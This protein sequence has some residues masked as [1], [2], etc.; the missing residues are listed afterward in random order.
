MLQLAVA[1]LFL[2]A[3]SGCLWAAWRVIVLYESDIRRP[4]SVFLG[5]TALWAVSNLF[6]LLPVPVAVMRVSYTL[7]LFVGITT[8]V[9]WLWFCSAYAGTPY[10]HSRPIQMLSIGGVATIIA[11]KLTNPLHGLYFRPRVASTPFRH[12][13]PEVG[14]LYWVVAGLAYVGA[15][16]GMYIL[17]DTY[18]SSQ[19]NAN[20][21]VM[22]T[23]LIGLP[24]APKLLA[25]MWL[26]S[27]VLIFYEPLGAAIFGVGI[28]TVARDSFLAVRAPARRQLPDQLSEIIIVIDNRRRIADYNDSA[29]RVF[30]NLKKS[31]GDRLEETIPALAKSKRDNSLF[32]LQQDAGLRYYT[33]REAKIQ[34]GS[35][36][37]GRAVVLSDVTELETQRHRLK[38]QTEHMESVTKEIAHQLRNP[39]TILKG[40]LELLQDDADSEEPTD[41]QVSNGSI[42]PA[43]EATERIEQIADDLLSLI[44]YG[45]PITET[46]PVALS[47]L[48]REG[49][50]HSENGHMEL[51]TPDKEPV[52]IV[53]ERTRCGE[54]FRLLFEVHRKR[55]AATINISRADDQLKISS[56]GNSFDTDTPR[57]LFE[58]GVETD[59]DVRMLLAHTRT[60]ARV[61]GWSIHAEVAS[62]TLSFVID[63]MV[64]VADKKT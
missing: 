28:V 56:D 40:E 16:I 51:Q 59:E 19:F 48:L 34:L 62:D 15:A 3:A 52:A 42:S 43:I 10:H 58:Y 29:E 53:T 45:R 47:A 2:V 9:V 44:N 33:V 6:L 60:L 21:I 23:V 20:K 14:V 37:I 17:F 41:N 11:L 46:E 50:N 4:L 35:D 26:E 22:L 27:L 5:L 38:Q 24:V 39:L 1:G 61:H 55:G 12:F 25:G 13:A 32:E 54:L 18:Y 7:G 36:G 30:N 31:L 49:F 63:N 57:E 8:V 64:F